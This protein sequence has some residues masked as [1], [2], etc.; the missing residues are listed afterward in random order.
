MLR[1]LIISVLLLSQSYADC[2]SEILSHSQKIEENAIADQELQDIVSYSKKLEQAH[3]EQFKPSIESQKLTLAHD[4]YQLYI[5]V[6]LSMSEQQLIRLAKEAKIYGGSLILR[7]LKNNSFKETQLALAALTNE[8]KSGLIINP[9]LFEEFDIQYVP[10][11]VI[12]AETAE[13]IIS[14]DKIS[15]NI[16]ITYFLNKVK[17][18]GDLKG[19][20]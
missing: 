9:Q 20:L 3:I 18:E 16:S 5:F 11:F 4:N 2:L 19:V 13:K 6:S 1:F 8:T 17:E 7:G 12:K 14:Q 10:S 15:G